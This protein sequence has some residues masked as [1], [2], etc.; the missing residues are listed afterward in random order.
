MI[1]LVE[2]DNRPG[3]LCDFLCTLTSVNLVRLESRA[4]HGQPGISTF[5]LEAETESL[6]VLSDCEGEARDVRRLD[7]WPD[8]ERGYVV[9]LPLRI[10]EQE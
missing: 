10:G 1:L 7:A 2:L 5:L 4:V 8:T 9:Q 3:S 6:E